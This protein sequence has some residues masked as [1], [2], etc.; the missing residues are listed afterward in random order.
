MIK[1]L[2]KYDNVQ[3]VPNLVGKERYERAIRP[4]DYSYYLKLDEWYT[5]IGFGV[6]AGIPRFYIIRHDE[7]NNISPV[8]TV[9]FECPWNRIPDNWSMRIRG[10]SGEDIEFFPSELAEIDHWF[11]RYVDEDPEILHL[12]DSIVKRLLNTESPA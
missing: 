11:E 7:D 4:L 5:V 10:L 9:L 2:G 12:V 8:P 3:D 6:V 1:V